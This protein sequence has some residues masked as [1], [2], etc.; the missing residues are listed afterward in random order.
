MKSIIFTQLCVLLFLEVSAQPSLTNVD[1]RILRGNQPL[2][3]RKTPDIELK[4]HP[5]TTDNWY[6]GSVILEDSSHSNDLKLLFKLNV[7]ESE[8]WV[9]SPDKTER[10][11]TDSRIVGLRLIHLDTMIEY[12]KFLLPEET[13][14]RFAQIIQA[15]K[16]F[17][18][19][20][21]EKKKFIPASFVDKGLVV[22]GNKFDTFYT[23]SHFKFAARPP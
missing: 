9:L 3:S 1:P 7:E 11:L 10:I 18:L 8:I 19:V 4:G 21:Y 15:G 23:P 12:R 14:A 22:I 20:R 6:S 17:T 5:F 16:Q 13:A 2:M